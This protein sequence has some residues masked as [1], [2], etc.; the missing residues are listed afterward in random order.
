[1]TG[2]Q[3]C[4]LP[5]FALHD[6]PKSWKQKLLGVYFK[7]NADATRDQY[8]QDIYA[9]VTINLSHLAS[10][11]IMYCISKDQRKIEKQVFYRTLYLT[12]KILQKNNTIKLHQNLR[13][14]DNYNDLMAG[15]NIR[16]EHFIEV[17]KNSGLLNNDEHNF[18]FDDSLR[19]EYNAQ[20]IRM[21]NLIA[22]YH[23]EASP[24][25]SVSDA[26]AKA[27]GK[28]QKNNSKKM[29]QS[30]FDD[31][32]LS[33]ELDRH[34]YSHER[35]DDINKHETATASAEPFLYQPEQSN[36]YGVLLIHGLLAS[37]AEVSDY[38][39]ELVNQGYIVLG[40]RVKGHGTSPHDLR[41]RTFEDW[42]ASVDR[43]ATILKQLCE[44]LIVIGFSTGGA[45]ALQY[46]AANEDS[47]ASVVAVAVPINFVDS[48][49][50][51]VPLLHGTNQLVQWLSSY[52][53]IKPFIHNEQENPD[54]NYHAIPV[55]SLYEL[56]RLIHE[57]E[58]NLAK[59]KVPTLLVYADHDPIVAIKSADT[60]MRT[61]ASPN[62]EL[63]IVHAERHGILKQNIGGTWS[64]INKFIA[65]FSQTD[66]DDHQ[67]Q[68]TI[69]T[70]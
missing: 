57:M 14:P 69:K 6:T 16:F 31:E 27:L 65:Q 58:D 1:M 29:A 54:I 42:Y 48:S 51:L 26:I 68:T 46:A 25:Q 2:V 28:A 49:L 37:P 45:L 47:V 39:Y 35:Y 53:G 8:M 32:I 59:I 22:V 67:P 21:E 18:Y 13:N 3:T 33:L 43:G 30:L 40:I 36:G 62:K 4:A 11:L 20:T 9:N 5:I 34:F 15:Q 66:E 63:N 24:I 60:I 17:A 56:R 50:M 41:S 10:T 23:N 61:L 55:R 44:Q 70:V 38:G 64:C 7:K 12:I 52:E 19:D